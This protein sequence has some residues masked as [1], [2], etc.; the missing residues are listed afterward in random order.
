MLYQACVKN[1]TDMPLHITQFEHMKK[2]FEV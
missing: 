2:I 1:N